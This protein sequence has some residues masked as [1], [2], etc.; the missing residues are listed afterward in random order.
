MLQVLFLYALFSTVYPLGKIAFNGLIEPI[1]FT[2]LSLLFASVVLGSIY[3]VRPHA[4]LVINRQFIFLLCALTLCNIYLTNVCEH[5]GLQYLTATKTSFMYNLSPFFSA[6]LS[7]VFLQEKVSCKKIVGMIIGFVGFIPYFL[8]KSCSEGSVAV[9]CFLFPWPEVALM[10]A[11][12]A[13]VVGWISMRKI[14]Q[15]GYSPLA[16]NAIS[17]F[18]GS[19]LMMPTSYVIGESWHPFPVYN[20]A[21]ALPII[22]VTSCISYITAYNLYGFLLERYT[23]TFL[24]VAGLSA[25]LWTALFGWLLLGETIGLNFVVSM[26][27]VILGII[28]FHQEEIKREYS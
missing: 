5:W 25:P 13:T 2:A 23:A 28:I 20:V 18:I 7:F 10:V 26:V 24:T 8:E 12:V 3:V 14:V 1:F 19:L 16:A 15:L 11:A 17:M 21:H 22:I 6:L 9:Q 4:P 27:I